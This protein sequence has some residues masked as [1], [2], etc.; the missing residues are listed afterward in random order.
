MVDAHIHVVPP[1][2]NGVGPLSPGL[3]ASVE[4]VARVVREQMLAGGFTH[5]AAM[6]AWDAG[7]DD[8]LGV[9]RTVQIAEGVPGLYAIG[10]VGAIAEPKRVDLLLHEAGQQVPI[11]LRGDLGVGMPEYPLHSGQGYPVH[12]EQAGRRV[13]DIVKTNAAYLRLG[14]Q[15]HPALGTATRFGI[16]M[17]FF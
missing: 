16:V 3:R 6:G 14:P 2:L 12:Q 1:N 4:N 13:S 9:N 10:V 15:P 8:P 11:R 5:A 7:P 17:T